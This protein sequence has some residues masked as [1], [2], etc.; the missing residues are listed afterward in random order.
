MATLFVNNK[1]TAQLNRQLEEPLVTASQVLP[2]WVQHLPRLFPFLF[3]FDTRFSFLEATAFGATRTISRWQTQMRTS[4]DNS[5]VNWAREE[6]FGYLG[7][8]SRKKVRIGRDNLMGSIVHIC[9]SFVSRNSVLETEYFDEVGTG[10]GP[11]LEFYSLAS[12]EFA[13]C[14]H[15]LWLGSHLAVDGPGCKALGKSK[16]KAKAKFQT[17]AKAKDPTTHAG[18]GHGKPKEEDASQYVQAPQGLFPI[19]IRMHF[20]TAYARSN[21]E[22]K[23]I[24]L[25]RSMGTFVAKSLLDSRIIHIDFSPVFLAL[26]IDFHV[27]YTL[28]SLGRIDRGL[29]SSLE[30]LYGLSEE[31][32]ASLSLDFTL[33]GDDTYELVREGKH[34]AVTKSNLPEYLDSILEAYVGQGVTPL[35]EAFRQGFA[36]VIDPQSLALFTPDE[37]TKILGDAPEDWSRSTLSTAIKPDHG[38]TAESPAFQNLLS[39]L[40]SFDRIERRVFL[41]WLTGSPKLP[42]GGFG[43]LQPP[44]TVVRRPHESPLCPDDYLPS[45]MTCVNYLKLPSYSSGDILQMR[46]RKA[47]HEGGHSFHLS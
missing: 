22:K 35:I 14:E 47:M 20:D 12:H 39:L 40:S 44:L 6:S 37:L 32:V 31:E 26:V 9:D 41:Q 16:P 30:K 4:G 42:I 25:F 18:H 24:H 1:L 19:P 11:T 17:K 29:A 23:R 3:P 27:P 36:K 34:K 10:L 46:I 45:V 8:L 5:A 2:E 13:S 38:F 33:P 7:R 28:D 15:D 21:R 43:A